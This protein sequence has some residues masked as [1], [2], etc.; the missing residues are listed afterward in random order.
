MSSDDRPTDER[1]QSGIGTLIILI[2]AI[3]VATMTVGVFFDVAGLLSGQTSSASEDISDTFD[4]R[5]TIVA[6]S[7]HVANG[8]I[9]RVNVTIKPSSNDASVDLRAASVQWV[10]PS[11]VRTYVWNGSDDGGPTFGVTTY[12]DGGPEGVLSSD[13]D[14]ATLTIEPPAPLADSDRVSFTL[15]GETE[16]SYRF[17]VPSPLPARSTV[18]L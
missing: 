4:G 9:D 5:V 14:R 11:G 15:V 3:L 12:N 17:R 18:G 8:E 7:G 1:A 16:I 6:V 13:T 2:A 10:G